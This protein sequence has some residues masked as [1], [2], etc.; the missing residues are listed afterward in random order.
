MKMLNNLTFHNKFVEFVYH[1]IL[2]ETSKNRL[3]DLLMSSLVP[4]IFKAKEIK[5]FIVKRK[6][7]DVIVF[8]SYNK[9]SFVI[10]G[11]QF[12]KT[13]YLNGRKQAHLRTIQDILINKTQQEIT[14]LY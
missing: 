14:A 13:D 2:S 10:R 3:Y 9:K 12:G 7:Q 5:K 6:P 4:P 11:F 1:T 8:V